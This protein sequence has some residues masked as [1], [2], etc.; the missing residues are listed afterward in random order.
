MIKK[1]KRQPIDALKI[2]RNFSIAFCLL[3]TLPVFG[4]K[5]FDALKGSTPTSSVS[6][7]SKN[8]SIGLNMGAV[9]GIGL[10]VAYRLNKRFTGKLALNYADYTAKG[11]TYSY[12]STT[13][14][15]TTN[16]TL[17][18]DAGIHLSNLALNI[19]YQTGAKGRFKL[20][21]GIAYFPQNSVSGGGQVLSALKFNDVVLNPEDIGSG[22]VEVGFSQK[23][24]PY[25]GMGFGRT[26]P[27][28]RL[29]VSFDLG[30]QYKGDYKVK[31][32]VK[33]G[34]LLKQNEEN[35]IVLARNFNEKWYGHFFP[36]L[37]LR[38]AYRIF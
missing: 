28:K 24:S 8:V 27:R 32:N 12:S 25:I 18:F 20:V 37:N 21:G 6:T 30:A 4:Q 38:L 3:T 2:L 14:G 11:I 23:I 15:T 17:S 36:V 22:D 26:F 1:T 35:A 7:A 13:N 10:D 16:Q 33:P 31:I 34:L 5:S 19:E 29:N 9:N